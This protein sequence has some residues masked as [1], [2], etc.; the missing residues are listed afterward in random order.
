MTEEI[1]RYEV[2][3]RETI[4]PEVYTAAQQL[5]DFCQKF[6]EMTDEERKACIEKLMKV[7][8]GR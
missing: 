3:G 6:A 1:A 4:R 8:P 2:K 7:A 5:E